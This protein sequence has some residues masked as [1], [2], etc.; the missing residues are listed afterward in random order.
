VIIASGGY[1]Q[2]LRN[3]ASKPPTGNEGANA[4][5]CREAVENVLDTP[6]LRTDI[7]HPDYIQMGAPTT[8]NK[9]TSTHTTLSIALLF[10]AFLFMIENAIV[11]SPL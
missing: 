5:S 2:K 11:F 3:H 7:E 1:T 4:W 10:Y 8:K 9:V 6:A